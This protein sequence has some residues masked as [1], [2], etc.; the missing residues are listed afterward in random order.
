MLDAAHKP[1]PQT[2]ADLDGA[3]GNE[4][5]VTL[6]PGAPAGAFIPVSGSGLTEAGDPCPTPAPRVA[7][8]SFTL[9]SFRRR[10]L[11]DGRALDLRPC[12]GRIKVGG[13]TPIEG[14]R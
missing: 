5:A 12:N 7:F 1:L 11:V 10:V 3:F 4:A 14:S 6:A 13:V 8:W 9:N 2:D